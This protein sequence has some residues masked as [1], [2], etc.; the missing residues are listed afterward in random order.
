MKKVL[1]FLA[2]MLV[3]CHVV[4][5][6]VCNVA[7]AGQVKKTVIN[8]TTISKS[9]PTVSG[10]CYVGAADKVS[11]FAVYE[12]SRATGAVTAELIA[13]VSQDASDYA[14]AGFF[15]YNHGSVM[16]SKYTLD[17]GGYELYSMWMPAAAQNVKI[18]VSLPNASVYGPGETAKVTVYMVK[19]E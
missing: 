11:F 10:E 8:E 3:V 14:S 4:C 16:E 5:N 19:D 18:T 7:Y 2:V 12:S 13:K 6:V 1:G 15:D 9:S 17:D